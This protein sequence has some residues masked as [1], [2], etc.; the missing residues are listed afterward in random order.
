MSGLLGW[1]GE[2]L[3]GDE[4]EAADAGAGAASPPPQEAEIYPVRSQLACCGRGACGFY[5]LDQKLAPLTAT[6]HAAG[7]YDLKGASL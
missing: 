7:Q 3:F 5:E 2:A 4:S 1:V 6:R